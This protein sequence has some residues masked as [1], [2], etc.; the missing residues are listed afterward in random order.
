MSSSSPNNIIILGSG[1]T[2]GYL[3]QEL[4]IENNVTLIDKDISKINQLK[5]K[6]SI[7][8]MAISGDAADLKTFNEIDLNSINFFDLN[9]KE[10]IKKGRNNAEL[11][12]RIGSFELTDNNKTI[13][14][15]DR[16][17]NILK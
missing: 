2:G 16:A 13:I 15:K 8:I 4:S 5:S 3:A 1:A 10:K 14:V 12:A 17:K 6:N 7:D 11:V 9:T